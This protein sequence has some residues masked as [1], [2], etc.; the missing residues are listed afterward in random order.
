M[1]ALVAHWSPAT[2]TIFTCYGELGISLWDVYRITGLPIVGEMY[3]EFFPAN[4][5]ILDK[6][7]PAS[8]RALFETWARLI[9]GLKVGSWVKPKFTSW[10][11]AFIPE[12]LDRRLQKN[13]NLTS[14]NFEK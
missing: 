5:L 13:L 6:T 12:A 3:D 2:N 8:L 1:K 10:V 9:K 14:E 7:R 11:K 4:R